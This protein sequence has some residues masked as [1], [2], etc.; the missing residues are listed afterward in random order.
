M[1]LLYHPFFIWLT[2]SFLA[3]FLANSLIQKRRRRTNKFTTKPPPSP[4]ALPIIGHL[5]LIGKV[6]PKSFQALA[7]T[8]GPLIQIRTGFSTCVVAS[9]E[10]VAKEIFKAQDLNFSS[11]PEFESGPTHYNIYRGT[12]FIT[13]QYSEYW[14]FMRKLCVTRLFCGS[15]FDRF[16]HIRERE[17]TRL[18]NSL[19][20]VS[21]AG[22]ECDLNVELETLANNV[23]CK[24]VM[25]R[26][27]DANEEGNREC[28][29]MRRMVSEIMDVAGKFGVNGLFG[30]LKKVDLFGY[31]KKLQD[32]LWKYDG[33]M[34]EIMKDYEEK[35]EE[36]DVGEKDVMDILVETYRDDNAQ[37][38]LTRTQIKHFIIELLMASIDTSAATLQWTMAELINRPTIFNKLRQEIDSTIGLTRPVKESDIQNLPYL[39]AVVKESL[40]LHTAAPLIPRECTKDC[41]VNGF[42]VKTGTRVLVNA[43]AI[44]RDPDTWVEPDKFEPER[45][46][47]D[48]RRDEPERFLQDIQMDYKGRDC[49][50]MP[51]GGGRRA[52][53][54]AGHGLMV[55]HSTVGALVQC[56]DWRVKGGMEK[57]DIKL[58]TGYS[59]A[60]ASPLVCYPVSRLD[61]S[62]I[63]DE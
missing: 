14:R 4:P 33:L 51:F 18:V 44:M 37:V 58:V 31:G 30:V 35:F 15:Q 57:V 43:Y 25:R 12:G 13:G 36:N 55:T 20:R 45:F 6:L 29:E 3:I 26:R 54:G 40:R 23:V 2:T 47:V 38:K 7:Q 39:R 27:F 61:F 19:A 53:P 59:G 48:D 22:K 50:F 60:M 16:N 46:L 10:A 32:A 5:H 49:L 34:E 28:K 21:E 41:K 56:F 11:R 42:H 52:C 17:L 9:N 1:S 63:L 62:K 24:M 8:Y